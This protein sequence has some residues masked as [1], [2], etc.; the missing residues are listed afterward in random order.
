M[1]LPLESI[2]LQFKLH[3]TILD[4]DG[5]LDWGGRFHLLFC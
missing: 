4:E 1:Q 5:R 3:L 2:G